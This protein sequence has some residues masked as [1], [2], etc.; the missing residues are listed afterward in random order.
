MCVRDRIDRV[1]SRLIEKMKGKDCHFILVTSPSQDKFGEAQSLSNAL[2]NGGFVTDRCVI[3]QAYES[4]LDEGWAKGIDE[5]LSTDSLYNYYR[6]ERSNAFALKKKLE[7]QGTRD[8]F[9]MPRR[10]FSEFSKEEIL[11]MSQFLME[12]W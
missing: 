10:P 12:A 7:D 1:T 4:W 2:N 5:D 11:K 3:N 8:V 9:L 6:A